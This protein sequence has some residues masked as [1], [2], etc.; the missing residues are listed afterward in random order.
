MRRIGMVALFIALSGVHSVGQQIK[1]SAPPANAAIQPKPVTVYSGGRGVTRPRLLPLASQEIRH[2]KG[3]PFEQNGIVI[4]SL[5]V[6][7]NGQARNIML[8]EPLGNDLDRFAVQIAEADRF[9]PGTYKRRPVVVARSLQIDMDTCVRETKAAGG[10][11]L[12]V[13]TLRSMPRQKLRKL[14]K[15]PHIAVLAPETWPDENSKVELRRPDYFAGNESTPVVI[16]SAPADYAPELRKKKIKGT[17]YISLVVDAHGLP[18]NVQVM[19]S[20]NPS[21]DKNAVIAVEQYRFF[22]AIRNNEP[23]PS[24]ITIEVNF[25]PPPAL[26]LDDI[27]DS[28]DASQ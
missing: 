23:V 24:A 27:G 13:W 3:C 1:S 10:K 14:P 2:Q 28:Y 6:D 12:N 17:T 19:R 25:A 20:L 15:A 4:L 8:L 16:Y 7:T 22:P 21:L 18:E 9:T 26:S 5:L 11:Y